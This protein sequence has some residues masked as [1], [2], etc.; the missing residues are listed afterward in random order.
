MN[1]PSLIVEVAKN[2]DR[3]ECRL[4]FIGSSSTLIGHTKIY[5]RFGNEVSADPNIITHSLRCDVCRVSWSVK[6]DGQERM[7]SKQ[8]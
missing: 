3:K 2:C 7:V 1:I 6:D 5:D 4:S 8:G